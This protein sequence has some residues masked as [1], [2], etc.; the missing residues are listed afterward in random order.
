MEVSS[1]SPDS[2]LSPERVNQENGKPKN[3]KSEKGAQKRIF[4]VSS[5]ENSEAIDSPSDPLSSGADNSSANFRLPLQSDFE[6]EDLKT[7]NKSRHSSSKK[8]RMYRNGGPDD[9]EAEFSQSWSPDS[10]KTDVSMDSD[11]EESPNPLYRI[12][13]SSYTS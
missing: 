1:T 9:F 11:M 6:L 12:R 7:S 13:H 8:G 5:E 3:G 4:Y 2:D 10:G